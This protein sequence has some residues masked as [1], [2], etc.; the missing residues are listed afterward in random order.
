MAPRR[1]SSI[2]WSLVR[3]GHVDLMEIFAE[4]GVSLTPRHLVQAQMTERLDALEDA[5]LHARGDIGHFD[6]ERGTLMHVAV[7][8][9]Q[10]NQRMNQSSARICSL[11]LIIRKPLC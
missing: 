2:P 3:D 7:N 10:Y 4:A 9:K 6:G 8:E 11:R 5:D 1:C